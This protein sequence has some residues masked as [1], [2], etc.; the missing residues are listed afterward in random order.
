MAQR[1]PR[2][3]VVIFFVAVFFT[4]VTLGFVNDIAD[5]GRQPALRFG[6]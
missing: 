4:F 5:L 6:I 1:V 2:R 3:A